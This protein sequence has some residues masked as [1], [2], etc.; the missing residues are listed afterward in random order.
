VGATD[1]EDVEPR[2]SQ[3][4]CGQLRSWSD[5]CLADAWLSR[6]SNTAVGW[7]RREFI[8]ARRASALTWI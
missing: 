5:P 6:A 7:H 2:V 1:G 3:S 4:F 8:A